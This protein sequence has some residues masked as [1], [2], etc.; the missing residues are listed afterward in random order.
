MSVLVKLPSVPAFKEAFSAPASVRQ[1][2]S[3]PLAAR[4][5]ADGVVLPH[6]MLQALAGSG[7]LTEELLRRRLVDESALYGALSRYHAIGLA[8]LVTIRPDPRLVDKIG[9]LDCLRLGLLPWRCAGGATVIAVNDP[10]DFTRHHARLSAT[11]GRVIPALAAPQA[12]EA[13]VLQLRGRS[14]A[15]AAETT[16]PDR[17]SC[18][19]WTEGTSSKVALAC[20]CLAGVLAVWPHTGFLA[21]L[22]LTLALFVATFTLKAAAFWLAV[23]RPVA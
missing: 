19:G 9:A 20:M 5:L 15:L 22:G 8:D 2:A 18:R 16:V 11:F 12:L 23:R 3:V 21:L 1:T 10:A 17:E 6:A 7:S 4:L 13:A 14:L